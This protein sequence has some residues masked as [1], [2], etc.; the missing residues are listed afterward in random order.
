[1]L[2]LLQIGFRQHDSSPEHICATT[3]AATQAGRGRADAG[4]AGSSERGGGADGGGRRGA[5]A[6]GALHPRPDLQ[7]VGQESQQQEG[8]PE[9]VR[10]R[11]R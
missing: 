8:V 1:M 7:G 10:C 6:R 4:A 11:R 2:P 5:A 3:A 9:G